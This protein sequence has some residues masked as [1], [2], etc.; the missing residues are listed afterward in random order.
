MNLGDYTILISSVIV[1]FG[2]FVNSYL[3]RRHEISKK[4]LDLRMEMLLSFIPV[5]LSI[6]ESSQPFEDDPLLLDKIRS[7]R[8][9]FQ[10]YG[11]Q[12]EANLLNEFVN[13]LESGKA[14]KVTEKV[15]KLTKLVLERLR[16]ELKLPPLEL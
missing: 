12:D 2:W 10:L 3:N 15:Q 8:I 6:N 13:A 1:V 9:K 7:T 14:I 16:N 11:Y 5:A 4:R